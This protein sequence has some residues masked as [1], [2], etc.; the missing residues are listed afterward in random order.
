MNVTNLTKNTLI[1][2]KAILANS[3]SSRMIGLLNRKSINAGEA[4]IITNCQSIHMFFMK[5]SIDVI[6]ISADRRIV[7]LSENIQP[8]HLSPHFWKSKCAIELPAGTVKSSQSSIGDT[9]QIK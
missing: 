5:F 8:F 1:A 7:G 2:D 4:L 6:F 3:F 9:I